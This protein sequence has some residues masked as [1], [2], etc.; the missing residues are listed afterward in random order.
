LNERLRFLKYK[1]GEYFKPHNDGIY[2]R[3]D[4][5]QLSYV[6]VHLYL[7]TVEDNSGGETTFTTAPL[8]YGKHLKRKKDP[9]IADGIDSL[10]VRPIAGRV[11][12]FEHHL[13]H[14]GSLLRHGIKYTMR[15]DIMYDLNGDQAELKPRWTSNLKHCQYVYNEPIFDNKN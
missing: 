1:P 13:P 4:G 12:I 11:L 2:V 8:S 14:E 7:N 10:G 3:E 9:W 5:S 15:T 6:T